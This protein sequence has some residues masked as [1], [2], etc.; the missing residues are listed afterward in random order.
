MRY[1]DKKYKLGKT[2]DICGQKGGDPEKSII[3]E[4]L[5]VCSTNPLTGFTRDGFV[6]QMKKIVEIILYVLKWIKIF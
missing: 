1:I 6:K 4:E 3:N 5:K 2:R